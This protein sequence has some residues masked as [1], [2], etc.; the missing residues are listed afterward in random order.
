MG[1]SWFT[2]NLAAGQWQIDA[3]ALMK[4]AQ[5]SSVATLPSPCAGVPLETKGCFARG[6]YLASC[7]AMV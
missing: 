4:N 6:G 2:D 3:R 5:G 1:L 7:H